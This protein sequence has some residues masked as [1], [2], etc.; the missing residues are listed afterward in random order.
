M[1]G[2]IIA[3][4]LATISL[5]KTAS[6]KSKARKE[7]F[8]KAQNDLMQ[9]KASTLSQNESQRKEALKAIATQYAS[10]VVQQ[11]IEQQA[12]QI[13]DEKVKRDQLIALGF[14]VLSVSLFT[15]TILKNK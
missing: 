14:G 4:T 9:Q 13:A 15:Y 10:N 5:A 3:G 7:Y 12:N 2:L 11:S 1:I 8:L 6:D